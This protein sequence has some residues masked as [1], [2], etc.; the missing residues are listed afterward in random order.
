[1][2]IKIIHLIKILTKEEP[3]SKHIFVQSFKGI[4][5]FF[6]LPFINSF[7]NYKKQQIFS[8]KM[9]LWWPHSQQISIKHA[10][11]PRSKGYNILDLQLLQKYYSLVEYV[12][13]LCSSCPFSESLMAA[14]HFLK[15]TLNKYFLYQL[16]YPCFI[17]AYKNQILDC[18]K[19]FWLIIPPKSPLSVKERLVQFSSLRT[20]VRY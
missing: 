17:S 13:N 18:L 15:N 6:R 16:K 5:L 3:G 12:N 7:K 1:M 4:E 2:T 14:L 10:Q 11:N 19:A 8:T 20:L 9:T